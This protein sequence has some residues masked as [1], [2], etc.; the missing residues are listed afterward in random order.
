[1]RDAASVSRR[2]SPGPGSSCLCFLPSRMRL[3]CWP[4]G[5]TSPRASVKIGECQTPCGWGYPQ[6]S[7]GP[8]K[9]GVPSSNVFLTSCLPF[10][11]RANLDL[12]FALCRLLI[13][14]TGSS[15]LHEILSLLEPAKD[16]LLT[17]SYLAASPFT[18]EHAETLVAQYLNATR[19]H[20][21]NDSRW[22]SWSVSTTWRERAGCVSEERGV[23]RRAVGARGLTGAPVP[24][25]V[26][27][28]PPHFLRAGPAPPTL[29]AAALH[30]AGD[31]GVQ[32]W[33]RDRPEGSGPSRAGT[34]CCL[35]GAVGEPCS[36]ARVGV[37]A[38]DRRDPRG[39]CVCFLVG[40]LVRSCVAAASGDI[41]PRPGHLFREAASLVGRFG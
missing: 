29:P 38:A 28:G 26:P 7:A 34:G 37:D 3:Y 9:G 21:A 6:W 11:S 17:S 12:C 25:A 39:S 8:G 5:R 40:H 27:E 33:G 24:T 2:D 19:G 4:S 35:L 22:C 1:M 18:G 31:P 20:L 30:A 14:G 10:L 41:S 15:N 32:L 23:A 36:P 13:A 16:L